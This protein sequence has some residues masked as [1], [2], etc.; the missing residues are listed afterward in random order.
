MK[1]I[2]IK[3][4]EIPKHIIIIEVTDIEEIVKYAEDKFVFKYATDK[5][6]LYYIYNEDVL[7]MYIDKKSNY[8]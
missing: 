1:I 3:N 4:I 6:C 7:L 8:Y 2:N 5:K